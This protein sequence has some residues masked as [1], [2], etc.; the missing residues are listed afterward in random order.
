MGASEP[1]TNSA[2]SVNLLK[3]AERSNA[4]RRGAEQHSASASGGPARELTRNR[5][6]IT[7]A[8][9]VS[10]SIVSLL[11]GVLFELRLAETGPSVCTRY[12]SCVHICV[13]LVP[14]TAGTS[15][16]CVACGP[17]DH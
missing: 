14:H 3:Q 10:S 8:S 1:L 17:R 12:S 16:E 13:V 5:H 7:F 9:S 11:L 2:S 6:Y 15:L 4:A